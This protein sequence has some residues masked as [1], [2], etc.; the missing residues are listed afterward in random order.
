MD[1][2]ISAWWDDPA[3]ADGS[4]ELVGKTSM[5]AK[6]KIKGVGSWRKRVGEHK[7]SRKVELNTLGVGS[8][9]NQYQMN[10]FKIAAMNKVGQLE[11]QHQ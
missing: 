9:A 6:D 8:G 2:V 4:K 7:D 1:G 3:P 5:K 11:D 10:T